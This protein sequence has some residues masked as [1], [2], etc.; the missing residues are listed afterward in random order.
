[1]VENVD[2]VRRVIAAHNRG[3][4]AVVFGAYHPDIE[5]SLERL[6]PLGGFDRV[7]RGHEGIRTFWRTWFDAWE[8]V[9]FEYE[10]FIETGEQV[11]SILTQR[12]RGRS[13]GLEVDWNSYAQVWTIRGG[14][15]V[16]VEFFQSRS[17]ALE[18]G[19]KG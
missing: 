6:P 8:T 3:E 5:W 1:V 7:Y 9:S 17:E 14:K 12:M 10:E 16:R 4:F 2:L 18:A 15:I 13:S 11:V 19:P